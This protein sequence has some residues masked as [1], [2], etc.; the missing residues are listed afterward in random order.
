MMIGDVNRELY[1]WS[2]EEEIKKALEKEEE[3][4][5]ATLQLFMAM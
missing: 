1:T 2:A 3:R 4:E 5:L